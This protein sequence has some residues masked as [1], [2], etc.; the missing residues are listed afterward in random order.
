MDIAQKFCL[1]INHAIERQA[2]GTLREF[3]KGYHKSL[4][5]INNE[6]IDVINHLLKM[7]DE[8]AKQTGPANTEWVSEFQEKHLILARAYSEQDEV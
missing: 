1:H 7:V 8:F 2:I 5:A 3:I 6:Q 4:K